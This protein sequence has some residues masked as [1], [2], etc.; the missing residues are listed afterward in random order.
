MRASRSVVYMLASA[1]G[2]SVM[3]VL[4]KVAAR[5]LPTGEIVTARAVI[6]LA[7]SYVMVRRAALSPWGTNHRG[8]LFRGVLGFTALTCYYVSIAALPLADAV[9]IQNT[10]PVITAVLGWWLLREYVGWA[11]LVG[12][13]CG[14]AGVVLIAKPGGAGLDATGALIGIGGAVCSA[15]AYVTVRELTRTEHPLVIVFYFPLV[16]VP[17]SLPW[18]IATWQTPNLHELGL[19]IGI[20]LTTQIGQVFMT[21]ALALEAASRV[22]AIGYIQIAFGLAWQWV[23]FSQVPSMGSVGG[24]ALII[25]GTVVVARARAEDGS[26]ARERTSPR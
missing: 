6:T 13:A 15:T 2:F 19:L 14:M 7:V 17:L 16:T 25:A 8:L 11:A 24:A 5:T 10:V 9:T 22:T 18:A 23:V 21:K 26:R 4:V 12:L 20:G 1:L 3:S